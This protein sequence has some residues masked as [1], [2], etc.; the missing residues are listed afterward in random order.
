[1]IKF[2][3]RSYDEVTVWHEVTVWQCLQVETNKNRARLLLLVA[4]LAQKT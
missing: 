3:S 1:M 2:F 4:L